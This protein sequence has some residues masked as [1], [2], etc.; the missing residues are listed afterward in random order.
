MGK[1]GARS[2]TDG[3]PCPLPTWASSA[4]RAVLTEPHDP[5]G[6]HPHGIPDE[7]GSWNCSI[8]WPWQGPVLLSSWMWPRHRLLYH[9]LRA[10]AGSKRWLSP[11][12]WAVCPATQRSALEEAD[13]CRLN[14]P[15]RKGPRLALLWCWLEGRVRGPGQGKLGWCLSW[16]QD[17]GSDRYMEV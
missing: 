7:Q 9:R 15:P 6:G 13:P 3:S 1:Q 5:R 8:W 16:E 10:V 17:L 11:R 14:G 12:G 2:L 4:A